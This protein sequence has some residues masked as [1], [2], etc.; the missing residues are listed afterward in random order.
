LDSE[1]HDVVREAP[2]LFDDIFGM[3]LL[4]EFAQVASESEVKEYF[5]EGRSSHKTI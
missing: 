5:I 2:S 3:Q 4:T 1:E